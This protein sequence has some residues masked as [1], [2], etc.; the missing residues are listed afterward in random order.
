M[1]EDGVSGWLLS[2]VYIE[3]LEAA[4][5][6]KITEEVMVVVV[7]AAGGEDSWQWEWWQAED[8]FCGN[9]RFRAVMKC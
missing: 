2:M 3:F 6:R 5:V 7:V 8:E 9:G 1:E 4:R